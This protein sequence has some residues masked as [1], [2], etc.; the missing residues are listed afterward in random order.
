MLGGPVKGGKVLGE[1]PSEFEQSPENELVLSRGRMVPKFPWDAMWLGVCEWFGIPATGE[2]MDKIL[3]M[4]KNF[5]SELL[6][7]KDDLF[8][9]LGANNGE[10]TA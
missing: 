3:P 2:A 4:H 6:Y 1:Y 5:P 7:N 9:L 8:N 10:D